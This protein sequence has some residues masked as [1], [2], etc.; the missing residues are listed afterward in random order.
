MYI[1]KRSGLNLAVLRDYSPQLGRWIN[2]DP[3][4]EFGGQ[5]LYQYAANEPL[6]IIDYL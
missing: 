1:H 5:N 6:G 4:A 3:L 2:R